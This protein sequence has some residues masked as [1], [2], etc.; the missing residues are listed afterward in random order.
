MF[1]DDFWKTTLFRRYK[2]TK[3]FGNNSILLFL[4]KASYL[5]FLVQSSIRGFL[6]FLSKQYLWFW[7][8][9]GDHFF[10]ALASFFM[11]INCNIVPSFYADY[12]FNIHIHC[13]FSKVRIKIITKSQTKLSKTWAYNNCWKWLL[14]ARMHESNL[15]PY[16]LINS[17]N[18][19]LIEVFHIFHKNCINFRW[20]KAQKK[21]FFSISCK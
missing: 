1:F 15:R 4:H 13:I 19:L 10:L 16:R 14:A 21:V 9:V 12:S 6:V 20:T 2:R 11:I 5:L 3:V 7:T 17:P 18:N 8:I